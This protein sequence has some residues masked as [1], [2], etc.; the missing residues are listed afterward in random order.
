MEENKK[1]VLT[2][3]PNVI[4][5]LIALGGIQEEGLGWGM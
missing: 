3:Q 1:V 2:H 5:K 4:Q